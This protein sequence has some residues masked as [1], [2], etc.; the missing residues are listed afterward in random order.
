MINLIINDK[1]ISAKENQ[2]ILQIAKENNIKIKTLC[3][4][5]D[6]LM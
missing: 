1:K 5:E 2:T 6:C 4:L 3:F